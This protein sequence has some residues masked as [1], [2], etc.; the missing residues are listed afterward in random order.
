M[1]EKIK[2]FSQYLINEDIS[3]KEAMLLINDIKHKTI[4]IV[5]NN[6]KLIGSLTD[7]DIRRGIINNFSPQDSVKLIMNRNPMLVVDEKS[8]ESIIQTMVDKGILLLPKVNPKGDILFIYSFVNEANNAPLNNTMVIMAGGKGTR[9]LPKT[10]D[11]PKALVK[12][13]GKPMLEQIIIT[14]LRFGIRNFIISINY[15]GLKI[16][17]YFGDGS[18]WNVNITYIE[19]KN[20]LGTAGS[21]GLLKKSDDLSPLIVINCDVISELNYKELLN[22]HIQNNSDATLVVKKHELTNPYGVVLLDGNAIKGFEEKPV[23][24]NFINAGVYVLERKI[25]KLIES[26]KFL[27]MPVLLENAIKKGNHVKAFNVYEPWFDLGN[28]ED[29]IIANNFIKKS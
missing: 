26:N 5:S 23:Y 12:V 25:L 21:L 14:A 16:K 10:R 1:I 17:K 13:G 3:I 2:D 20:F 15:L 4:F 22:F 6:K 28:E 27:D 19:E 8:N 7:G 29:L 11:L 18:A 9:L 24:K